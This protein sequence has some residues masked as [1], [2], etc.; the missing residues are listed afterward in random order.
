MNTLVLSVFGVLFVVS[1]ADKFLGINEVSA[2]MGFL[3]V[4]AGLSGKFLA[5]IVYLLF[6]IPFIV[7][8]WLDVINH[9]KGGEI[10]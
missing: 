7:L 9:L 1:F 10:K 6:F 3:G 4:L 8:L 2:F 5:K